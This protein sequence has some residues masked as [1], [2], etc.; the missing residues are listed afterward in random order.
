MSQTIT[1]TNDDIFQQV[2]LSYKIPEIIEQIVTRKIISVAAEEA[3]IKIKDKALQKT[4]DTLRLIN[5][6]HTAEDTW[7]WLQKHGLSLD[8]FEEIAY[9]SL[10]SGKLAKH[11][12]ADKVEPWF[13]EYQLDYVGVAMYEVVL[14]DEDLA[15]ELF[16]AI[17]EGEVSF[18]DVAHKYVQD[19]ELR[20]HGGYRGIVRRKDLK[21][22]ISAAVFA[23]KPP[24]LLKPIV[25]SKG[26]H[27]ILVEELIQ[28]TLDEKLRTNILADLF[29]QWL[30]QQIEP[31]EIIQSF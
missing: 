6:L 21:P 19:T 31:I 30:K 29:S 7:K 17:K 2:K 12:F 4:A 26:V 11:L 14:D 23:A 1:V 22:E 8:D 25:T 9:T 24:Q 10:I 27:L 3:G 15:I 16:Y 28:P 20:R 18:Y 5:N 13:F